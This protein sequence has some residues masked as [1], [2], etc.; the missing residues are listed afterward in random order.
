MK[1]TYIGNF[2]PE[3]S[4]E[5]DVRKAFEFLGHTVIPVQENRTPL[6]NIARYCFDSDLVL[7]TGTQGYQPDLVGMIDLF[8]RLALKDIPTATYHLDI[9]N[10]ISRSNVKWWLHP[11]FYTKYIFTADG[12]HQAEWDKMDMR[13]NW[14]MPGVRYDACHIGRFREDYKCDVAFV[15]SNGNGYHPEWKYRNE[16]L[17]NLRSMCVRNNW[18]FKNPG[19]DDP[20]INRNDDMN[21]FYASAKV[22]IGDSLCLGGEASKYF[23]DR[24]FEATGRGGFL[25]MPRINKLRTIFDKVMPL[26]SWGNWDQLEKMIKDYLKDEY[27]RESARKYCYGVTKADHT[28]VNRVTEILGRME[29]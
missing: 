21:D 22:T 18:V 17:E 3:Y 14:I 15:G 2:E 16:L 13:H 24:V 28:Y 11:M 25:I 27:A 10:G 26:Y 4:T 7:Y 29:L 19:G 1:V 9:F 12:D 8:K 20:K 23:S 6:D 5:N